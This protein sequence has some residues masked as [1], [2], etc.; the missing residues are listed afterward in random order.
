MPMCSSGCHK[1]T[2]TDPRNL[3]EQLALEAAQADPTIGKKLPITLNDPR[4]PS[5]AGWY[6]YQYSGNGFKIHYVYN[7]TTG[8]SAD[9]KF[10]LD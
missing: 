9:Y 1:K 5:S 6:K 4:W 7:A 10:I 3:T 2:W 8:E